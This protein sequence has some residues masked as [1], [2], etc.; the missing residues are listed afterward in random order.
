MYILNAFLGGHYMVCLE[1]QL[2]PKQEVKHF[3]TASLQ[4]ENKGKM[5]LIVVACNI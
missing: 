2:Q 3:M 1:K 5:A 4:E